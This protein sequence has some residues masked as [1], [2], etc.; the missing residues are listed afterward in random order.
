MNSQYK[1]LDAADHKYN[2]LLKADLFELREAMYVDLDKF[3][4]SD[5][6]VRLKS[7]YK[8]LTQTERRLERLY[9]KAGT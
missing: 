6:F 4:D 5:E 8:D 7:E 2:K 3:I 9:Q 1:A